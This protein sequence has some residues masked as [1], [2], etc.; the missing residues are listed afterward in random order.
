[1]LRFEIWYMSEGQKYVLWSYDKQLLSS[2]L[3]GFA[4]LGVASGWEGQAA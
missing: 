3:D 4:I 1:M 2:L